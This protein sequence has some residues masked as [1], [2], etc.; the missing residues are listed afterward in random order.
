MGILISATSALGTLYSEANPAL[1][2]TD[3]YK[4]ENKRNKQIFRLLGKIPTIAACVSIDF[5]VNI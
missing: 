5:D 4:D 3:I 1:Q 2:G